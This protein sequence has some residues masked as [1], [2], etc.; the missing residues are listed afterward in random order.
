[1]SDDCVNSDK[2]DIESNNKY[3][4]LIEVKTQERREYLPLERSK[5]RIWENFRLLA[6]DGKYCELDRRKWKLVYC[7]VCKCSYKYCGNTTNMHYH[8]KEHHPTLYM[9]LSDADSSSSSSTHVASVPHGQQKLC[10]RT[11]STTRIFPVLFK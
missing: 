11:I 5:S 10:T 7:R 4:V 9:A 6:R 8:L 2:Y 3:V 1:M